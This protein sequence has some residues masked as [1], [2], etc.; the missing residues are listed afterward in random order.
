[1]AILY[2][3]LYVAHKHAPLP[4]SSHKTLFICSRRIWWC[5]NKKAKLLWCQ[6]LFRH[7][8]KKERKERIERHK[9]HSLELAWIT[10]SA[11][12]SWPSTANAP[13]MFSLSEFIFIANSQLFHR[14]T[15]FRHRIPS[16]VFFPLVSRRSGGKLFSQSHHHDI[17]LC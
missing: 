6:Q 5:R 15:H 3:S 12:S 7:P 8:K 11:P 10:S 4:M 17:T 16:Y 13:S 1:M 2:L 9:T 14:L